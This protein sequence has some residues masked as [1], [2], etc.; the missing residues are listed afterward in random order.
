MT[1]FLIIFQKIKI[2]KVYFE[3]FHSSFNCIS[4]KFQNDINR[5]ILKLWEKFNNFI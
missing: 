4:I 2:I 3:E 1:F 5:I